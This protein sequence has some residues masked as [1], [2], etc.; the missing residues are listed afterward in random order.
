MDL[1]IRNR[2]ISESDNVIDIR[3][4]INDRIDQELFDILSNGI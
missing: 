1:Q 3:D 4:L 2:L